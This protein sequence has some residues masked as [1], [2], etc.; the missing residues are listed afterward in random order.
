M[1]FTIQWFY[2]ITKVMGWWSILLTIP[3]CST[4]GLLDVNM[5]YFR[6][7]GPFLYTPA[8]SRNVFRQ[9]FDSTNGSF[10]NEISQEGSTNFLPYCH[11]HYTSSTYFSPNICMDLF[12]F[13]SR[14]NSF[15]YDSIEIPI[16][17]RIFKNYSNNGYWLIIKCS[18][19]I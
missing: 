1:Y 16:K 14:T 6:V 18:H 4:L 8:V 12:F 19:K 13:G 9:R 5:E 3:N 17:F 10:S 15:S 2:V 7:C 11:K